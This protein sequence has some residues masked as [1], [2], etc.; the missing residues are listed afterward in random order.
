M[1]KWSIWF[2]FFIEGPL[3]F[4]ILL[5]IPLLRWFALFGFIG[6][7][8]MINVSGNYA[9]LGISTCAISLSVISDGMLPNWF[10]YYYNSI[11]VWNFDSF[12]NFREYSTIFYYFF[13]LI[14]WAYIFLFLYCT[15]ILFI[16]GLRT[17]C[18]TLRRPS[19]KCLDPFFKKEIDFLYPFAIANR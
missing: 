16:M 18:S 3:P 5:P 2:T 14:D 10:I 17:V 15:S 1:H 8:I 7:M 9:Y 4:F 19:P 11:L 13:Q 6:L 12:M